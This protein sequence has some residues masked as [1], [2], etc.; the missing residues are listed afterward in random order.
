VLAAIHV[1]GV[2]VAARCIAGLEDRDLV[3][4]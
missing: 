3:M 2:C 4:R 1:H